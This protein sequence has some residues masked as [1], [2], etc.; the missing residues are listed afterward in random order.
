MLQ[1]AGIGGDLCGL[2]MLHVNGFIQSNTPI[3]T[4]N[5]IAHN[6]F[7]TSIAVTR[8]EQH[9]IVFLGT[10]DGKLKKVIIRLYYYS[11]FTN[12]IQ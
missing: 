4:S 10:H 8:I 12:N 2:D 6:S 7:I 5:V 1:Q 9:T 3:A 11:Y